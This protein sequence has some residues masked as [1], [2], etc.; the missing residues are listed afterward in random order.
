[1]RNLEKVK[2]GHQCGIARR[3]KDHK[4]GVHLYIAA[5]HQYC[6][7]IG[8][9]TEARVAFVQCDLCMR[10]G[11]QRGGKPRDSTAYDSNTHI[12]IITHLAQMFTQ[13]DI[14]LLVPHRGVMEVV[15]NSV[16]DLRTG[17]NVTQEALA[18]AVGVTRQTIIAI[19][20][21]NYTPSVL[22]AIKFAHFFKKPVEDIFKVSYE[23]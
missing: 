10:C 20:K 17:R 5:T 12:S 21:G 11:N 7:S 3:V 8:V 2:D 14:A 6:L 4:P 15:K 23:K 22:L 1:M 13:L 9:P 16:H 18:E 19:E